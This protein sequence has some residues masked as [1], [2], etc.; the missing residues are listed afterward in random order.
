MACVWLLKLTQ[1][2][3]LARRGTQ[4]RE[5]A[6]VIMF[7]ASLGLMSAVISH[8][9]ARWYCC[10]CVSL[11]WDFGTWMWFYVNKEVW[12]RVTDLLI[13]LL[14]TLL[15]WC[16]VSEMWIWRWVVWVNYLKCS[17][18]WTNYNYVYFRHYSERASHF[19]MKSYMLFI[20]G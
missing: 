6:L 1:S 10:H 3:I 15:S 13:N 8:G 20:L 9:D 17:F 12:E 2:I 11:F 18:N 5:N 16:S 4:L 19:I 7:V 14:I